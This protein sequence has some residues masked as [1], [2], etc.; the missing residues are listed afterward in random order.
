MAQWLGRRSLASELSLFLIYGS[1]ATTLWSSQLS[2]P[3]FEVGKWVLIHIITWI[4][5]MDTIKRQTRADIWLFVIGQSPVVAGLAYGLQAVRSGEFK[6]GPSRLRP[7]P[8]G[9]PT[10]AITH[11]TNDMWQRY[12]IMATPSPFLSLQTRKTW[13][14]EYKMIATSGFLTASTSKKFRARPSVAH[15]W[16]ENLPSVLLALN[17][18]NRCGHELHLRPVAY[19]LQ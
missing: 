11:S 4:I 19:S 12:C 13:Y 7:P 9:R 18:K 17:P 8:F 6:G 5:K 1:H 2:L 16:R 10:D 14:S 15:H 3:S